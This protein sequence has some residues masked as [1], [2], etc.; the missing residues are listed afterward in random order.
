MYGWTISGQHANTASVGPGV[1]TFVVYYKRRTIGKANVRVVSKTNP[2]GER[3]F[4]FGK[5]NCDR[6]MNMKMIE[7]AMGE[8]VENEVLNF[9]RN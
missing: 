2:F 6:M 9:N 3:V 4:M 7:R 5:R 1:D 8:I